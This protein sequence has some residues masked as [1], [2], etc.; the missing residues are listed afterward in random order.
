MLAAT[1]RVRAGCI[2]KKS[3]A[4]LVSAPSTSVAASAL[5]FGVVCWEVGAR[6]SDSRQTQQTD[7]KGE[8]HRWYL[9][10]RVEQVAEVRMLSRMNV[11][12]I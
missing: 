9:S 10:G 5:S 3:C 6:T 4:L 12:M 1:K 11:I 2:F 7:S 8:H